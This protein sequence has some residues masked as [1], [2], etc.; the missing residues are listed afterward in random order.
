MHHDPG[1]HADPAARNRVARRYEPSAFE[2]R[3][4]RVPVVAPVD[5]RLKVHKDK[6]RFR[7][8]GTV[9]DRARAAVQP[10]SRAVSAAGRRR[11]RPPLSAASPRTPATSAKSKKTICR[12]RS[13]ATMQIDLGQLMEEQFYLALPMKPL[14]RRG[15]QGPV[16]ELRHQS[17]RRRRATARSAGKIPGW[18]A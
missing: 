17:E 13:I 14:C 18:R 6:D 12:T 8:V 11:L 16:P 1:S 10:L 5:L 2:G 7:L 9:V 3:N 15:L 4:E